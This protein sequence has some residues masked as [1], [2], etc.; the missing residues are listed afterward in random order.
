M[1]FA[2]A[3]GLTWLLFVGTFTSTVAAFFLTWMNVAMGTNF[4]GQL[5][6]PLVTDIFYFIA[7]AIWCLGFGM[8]FGMGSARGTKA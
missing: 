8:G 6:R 1:C 2:G 5:E 7:A 3:R 4:P